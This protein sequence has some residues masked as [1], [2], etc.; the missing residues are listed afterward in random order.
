MKG[1][2][3]VFKDARLSGTPSIRDHEAY[4]NF[5]NN[6]PLLKG[7]QELYKKTRELYEKND[8]AGLAALEPEGRRMDSI[9]RA[10]TRQWIKQHPASPISAFLLSYYLGRIDPDE[11]SAILAQLSPAAKENAPAKR[12]ANSVRVNNLTGIGKT[13]ID[14]TQK[15]T[16]GHPVSL[17]DF[18]G[19]YVLV[20]FWASWCVPCRQE[21]PNVVAAWKKYKDKNF[22]VL[23]VSLDQPTGK[24]KW[25]K[26]IH[27]DHLE[28]THVSDLQYWNNAVAKLYDINSIPT[29]LL[30]DPNGKIIAKDLHGK[31]LGKKLEEILT[32]QDLR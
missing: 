6:H 4:K 1:A 12:V 25:L 8:S 14:F 19:K 5:I 30:L 31:E 27:D 24:E 21:N 29:N 16:L 15:D 10:L 28:W 23:S 26:A 9:Q 7:R 2:G 17:K 18:R 20:D 32:Q 22:T 3:P 11:K 13:A